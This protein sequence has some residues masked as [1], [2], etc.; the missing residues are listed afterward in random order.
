MIDRELECPECGSMIIITQHVA[1]HNRYRLNRDGTVKFLSCKW[2][3][4][5]NDFVCSKDE[6]HNI[7]E[8][9]KISKDMKKMAMD[10]RDI[11]KGKGAK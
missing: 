4:D 5:Y 6:E 9:V 10:R 3:A 8:I 11:F 7:E 1:E 2:D